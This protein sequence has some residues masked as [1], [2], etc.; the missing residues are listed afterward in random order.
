MY[1]VIETGG[2]QYRV[3][4]GDVI[5]VERLPAEAGS[6]VTFDRV[7]MVGGETPKVGNPLVEGSSVVGQVEE[8]GKA[9]K[10]LII[11]FKRRQKYRRKQGHRQQYTQVRITDITA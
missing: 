8:H 4:T 1:A 9:D 6:N 3:S 7:L 11:K 2:K 10:V 5:K